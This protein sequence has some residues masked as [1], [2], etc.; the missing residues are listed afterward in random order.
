MKRTIFLLVKTRRINWQSSCPSVVTKKSSTIVTGCTDKVV[1]RSVYISRELSLLRR[2]TS[3]ERINKPMERNMW[4]SDQ[5]KGECDDTQVSGVYLSQGKAEQD[6]HDQVCIGRESTEVVD[7]NT[8]RRGAR[9]V[10]L[11]M[12]SIDTWKSPRFIRTPTHHV[13]RF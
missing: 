10:F 9:M 7:D 2:V 8:N 11:V 5:W 3:E 13:E 6:I 4:S 12:N 1:H